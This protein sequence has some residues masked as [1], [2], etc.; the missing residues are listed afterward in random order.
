[1]VELLRDP[2]LAKAGES[3]IDHSLANKVNQ[4]AEGDVILNIAC[5]GG[6]SL[7]L[8]VGSV[9][10]KLLKDPDSAN[11]RRVDDE[12]VGQPEGGIEVIC[13]T[14][15]RENLEDGKEGGKSCT[16]P[17]SDEVSDLPPVGAAENGIRIGVEGSGSGLVAE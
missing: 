3:K 10:C 4:H 17:L 13:D 15:H 6:A 11:Y 9:I 16:T 2:V 7:T 14:E 8:S 12:D 1:M 5:I